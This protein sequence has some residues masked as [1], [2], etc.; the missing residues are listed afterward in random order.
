MGHMAVAFAVDEALHIGQEGDEFLVVPFLKIQL[1]RLKPVFQPAPWIACAAL[2]QQFPVGL[3]VPA[4]R[5][6]ASVAP[7]RKAPRGNGGQYDLKR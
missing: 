6:A 7:A 5:Q 1:L 4:V 2:C 3:Y